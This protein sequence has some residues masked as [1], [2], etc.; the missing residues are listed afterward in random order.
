MNEPQGFTSDEQLVL[1]RIG[2][3]VRK[4]FSEGDKR[5]LLEINALAKVSA[6]VALAI[7]PDGRHITSEGRANDAD[8]SDDIFGLV[9][10][11]RKACY[12]ENSGTWF[13]ARIDVADSGEVSASYNY[14][15]EPKWDAPPDP[16][17]YVNDIEV[18]PRD[19]AHQPEW[20]KKQLT[21]GN[22]KIARHI[23]RGGKR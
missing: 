1:E 2:A 23:G 3:E 22:E 18:F 13:S 5:V 15:D 11:L 9:A 10:D 14:N 17:A 20:L 8:V 21:A 4:V 7:N 12:R 16:V 6:L 19:E